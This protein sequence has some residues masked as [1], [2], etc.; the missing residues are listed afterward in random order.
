ML[1]VTLY[2]IDLP[3]LTKKPPT[4]SS[5]HPS[6][7]QFLRS[8]SHP[9]IYLS[10]YLSITH[11]CTPIHPPIHPANHPPIPCIYPHLSTCI[12]T[13]AFNLF[14][15]IQLGKFAGCVYPFTRNSHFNK[16]SPNVAFPISFVLWDGN[17]IPQC[18]VIIGI[19][20]PSG[21]DNT[22]HHDNNNDCHGNA[23]LYWQSRM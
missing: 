9:S 14:Q 18:H 23:T 8:P 12:L 6:I 3:T 11:P 2:T 20:C 15:F 13:S 4:R 5:T 17:L 1:L 22:C 7:H 10:V 21:I 19:H 16:P